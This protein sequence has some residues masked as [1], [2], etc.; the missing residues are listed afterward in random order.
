M[1]RWV[2]ALSATYPLIYPSTP[3][4]KADTPL[5][6]RAEPLGNCPQ[7]QPHYGRSLR[8]DPQNL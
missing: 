6:A 2:D 8:T 4:L 3:P 1:S 5:T 7:R